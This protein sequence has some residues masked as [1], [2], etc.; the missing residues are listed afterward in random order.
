MGQ[1][2]ADTNDVI[3]LYRALSEDEL[4]KAK[5]L[6]PAVCSRLRLEAKKNGKN[7]DTM[8]AL[9]SDLKE[10]A[11]QVTVDIVARALMTP[12]SGTM[13]ALSQY[14]QSGLG[15]TESGTFLS[16]GGG[17]FIKKAELAALGIKKQKIGA[18]NMIGDRE[19][20]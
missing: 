9:D 17:L 12:T 7:L 4:A 5:A 3:A 2:Y 20:C 19:Q 11:K 16:P 18:I 15:Y 10:V 1:Q 8:I 6:I 13:G 14:S